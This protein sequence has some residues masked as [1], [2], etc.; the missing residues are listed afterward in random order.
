MNDPYSGILN[1]MRKQGAKYNAPGIQMGIVISSD[2]LIIKVGD[3]QI[4]KDNIFIADYLLKDYTRKISLP[5]T[6]AIGTAGDQN[7]SNISIPE[8][9]LNFKDGLKNNDTVIMFETEDAQKYIILA[10]VVEL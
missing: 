9:I 3:L 4:D 5:S 1:H 8:A 10:R 6:N 2:P 7:I